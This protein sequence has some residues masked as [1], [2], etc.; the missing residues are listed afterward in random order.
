[1]K[2]LVT[3]F[4]FLFGSEVLS[5]LALLAIMLLFC[6]DIFRARMEVGKE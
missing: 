3:A 4:L 1:M 5:L 2:Y 6:G